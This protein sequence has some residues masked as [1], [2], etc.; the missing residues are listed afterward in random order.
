[1][2]FDVLFAVHADTANVRSMQTVF[3]DDSYKYLYSSSFIPLKQAPL[4]IR[5]MGKALIMMNGLMSMRL[6]DDTYQSLEN[7]C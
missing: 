1:M 7:N 3:I 4:S 6:D 5:Y 2:N